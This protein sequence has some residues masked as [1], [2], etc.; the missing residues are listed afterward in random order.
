MAP[1][2]IKWV[3]GIVGGLVVA[4]I[5]YAGLIRPTTKPNPTTTQNGQ[6]FVNYNYNPR[7]SFG[8]SRMI[9]KNEKDN[10]SRITNTTGGN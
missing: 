7:V 8:C 10:E 6:N 9:I 1:T 3:G 4:W 2:I 5:V